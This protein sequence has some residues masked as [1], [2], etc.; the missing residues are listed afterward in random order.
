MIRTI[1]V[2][3]A[4]GFS[5]RLLLDAAL[6]V[7]KRTGA[8]IRAMFIRPEPEAALA[9]I[10]DVMIAARVTR[11]AFE[12]ES[13]QADSVEKTRFESWQVD[14]NI[15]GNGGAD[16]G[17]WF[18]TWSDR[19]GEIETLIARCGRVS[20]L[21]VVQRA[22]PGSFS[23][24]RCFDAAVFES[25]RPVLLIPETLPLDITDHVLIAWNGSL[26]ASRAVFGAMP[27]LRLA[28]RV[29]I[30]TARQDDTECADPNDL[31]DS[32]SLHGIR[33][34]IAAPAWPGSSTSV[35]LIGAATRQKATLIVMGAYTHSR[36]RQLFLG[37]VTRHLLTHAPVPLLMSH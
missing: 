9:D 35:A 4:E 28:N 31:A 12:S 26:E 23:A 21:T 36:L 27:L 19:V 1:F 16:A 30:F 20:D 10:P 32:L 22:A 6:L 15:S 8:H 17:S 37:G 25:G 11:E 13:R 2:P 33:I 5:S 14:N 18:A 3:L 24:Q 29:S 7:A 34:Q